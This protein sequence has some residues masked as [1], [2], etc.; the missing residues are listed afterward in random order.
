MR[1]EPAVFKARAWVALA[2]LSEAAAAG[3]AEPVAL[4][5]LPVAG[6]EL[7]AAAQWRDAE[8]RAA[9]MGSPVEIAL[10]VAGTFEGRQQLIVQ[11]NEGGE[12]S[13]AARVTVIR[14]GLLDDAVRSQ[15]WDIDFTR[16]A[17]GAWQIRQV[18]KAWRCWRGAGSAG[19][20]AQ[21]CP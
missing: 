1:S 10:A 16:T 15:R 11:V 20:A 19:F 21:P 5:D 3:A 6:R 4:I 9:R 7:I 2:L 18:G 14:D 13:S 12:A 17:A 8:V